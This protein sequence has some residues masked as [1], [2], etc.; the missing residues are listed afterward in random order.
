MSE[1]IEVLGVRVSNYTVDELNNALL[2]IV[3]QKEK[4][5]ALNVNIHGLNLAYELKWL[6]DYFNTCSIVFC[7]GEGVRLGARLFGKEIKEKITYNR[8]IWSFAEFS[9]KH[10][11]SWYLMGSTDPVIEQAVSRLREKYP[12]L[13]IAGYR[14]GF[15]TNE[16]DVQQTIRD[17]NSKEV[18]VLIL[19]M[20]MPVQEKWLQN[21][22]PAVQANIA[23]TGG[24]VFEYVSGNARMT[25]DIFYRLK[26]EWLYRF[27]QEPRRLFRRYIIG[28]PLFF[29]RLFISRI[30]PID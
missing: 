10:G 13:K 23:L 26:L 21:N 12:A 2:Q 28:N 9:E 22:W 8:W 11:L 24:A 17:I 15:F 1:K 19:G 3:D 25:P 6:R 20:G 7:D 18:N 16:A 30:R 14:N 5:L 4:Q 29:I 27:L